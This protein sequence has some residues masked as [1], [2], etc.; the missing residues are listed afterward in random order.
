MIERFVA[1]CI[2][3]GWVWAGDWPQF[4]GPNRDGLSAERGLLQTWPEGGPRKIWSANDLGRGFSSPIVV[5]NRV[6]ITGDVAHELHIFALDVNGKKLWTATNGLAW[7]REY[8]GARSSVTSSGLLYH[9]N[10]HGMVICLD[11]ASGQQTWSVDLLKTF[12]GKNINW[13]LSECLLVDDRVV[14]ATA[15][16]RDALVVALD[17]FDGKLI[18]K[19]EPLGDQPASY[20]SPILVEKDD[21]RFLV[22]CSLLSLFCVDADTGKILS[23]RPFPTSYSVLAMMP[24]RVGDSV[25]MTAPH[26]QGGFL[27]RLPGLEEIWNTSLDTCQGG[28]IYVND[29]IIGSFYGSRKGWATLDAKTGKILYQQPDF[30]KG[31]AVFGDN[32]LYA[33]SEDGWMRLLQPTENEFKVQGKFRLAEARGSDAWAHP[34][35][36]ERRLYLRYH[37]TLSCYDLNQ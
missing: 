29:K 27:L 35:I 24:T 22:G 28:A 18:W 33:L 7:R 14:Y 3:V 15:G 8:P 11:P 13:G 5:S 30:V 20:A 16:G 17:K 12:N 10:A 23:S 26:G 2:S 25:F 6:Y 34:V 9:A 36:S 32:R 1:L 4:R 37:D 19:S 31:A 21:R